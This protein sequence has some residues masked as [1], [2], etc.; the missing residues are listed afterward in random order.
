M[1]ADSDLAVRGKVQNFKNRPRTCDYFGF[2]LISVVNFYLQKDFA[3]VNVYRCWRKDKEEVPDENKLRCFKV[4][5]IL[6]KV[7]D[8]AK[9][10]VTTIYLF[11][12]S[13]VQNGILSQEQ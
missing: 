11:Y 1:A 3:L 12:F 6:R 7:L 9:L 4:R 2:L 8:P 5:K 10:V 13:R